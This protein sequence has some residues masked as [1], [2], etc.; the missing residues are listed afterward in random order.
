MPITAA[1]WHA[2]LYSGGSMQD[3]GTHAVDQ[4][5]E[6]ANGINNSGQ[7]V[8][9]LYRPYRPFPPSFYSGGSMQ[10]LGT[11]G[12]ATV[13]AFGINDSG[14]IVGFADTADWPNIAFLYTGGSMQ[15]LGTINGDRRRRLWHQ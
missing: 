11:L 4:Y 2:F 12:G 10:D 1:V 13:C 15:D 8:G 14:Q 6:L 5:C 3:L 9:V 7:V